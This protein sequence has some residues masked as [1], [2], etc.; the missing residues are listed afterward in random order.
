MSKHQSSLPRWLRHRAL[1]TAEAVLLV[2]AGQQLLSQWLDSIAM[3]NWARVMLTMAMTLGVL[4]GVILLVRGFAAKGVAQGHQVVKALPLPAASLLLHVVIF[5]A[6]FVLYA[7]VWHL[8]V[9]MPGW[10]VV[11]TGKGP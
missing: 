11:G 6:L 7:V 2:G 8:P 10:G 5:I 4:G 1:V 3:P 9:A